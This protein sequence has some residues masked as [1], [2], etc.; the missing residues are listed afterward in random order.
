MLMDDVIV[1]L[2][3]CASYPYL[4]MMFLFICM[5]YSSPP[6]SPSQFSYLTHSQIFNFPPST[7]T[8]F[9][10][11]YRKISCKCG[12]D[13][14][15]TIRLG[16][17]GKQS[18]LQKGRKMMFHKTFLGPKGQKGPMRHIGQNLS[19]VFLRYTRRGRAWSSRRKHVLYVPRDHQCVFNAYEQARANSRKHNTITMS[20][21]MFY[22]WRNKKGK[23]LQRAKK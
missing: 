19:V 11:L 22:Y 3:L 17:R 6:S 20:Q 1:Y 4:V 12:I 5:G 21:Q 8:T 10:F 14:T 15:I 23:F 2:K 16:F 7:N 13:D 18:K 9:L